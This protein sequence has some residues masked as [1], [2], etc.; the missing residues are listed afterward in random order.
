ME[1]GASVQ[2]PQIE[3]ERGV[4]R[5]FSSQMAFWWKEADDFQH[6][7]S[8]HIELCVDVQQQSTERIAMQIL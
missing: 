7:H 2:R 3:I 1:S 6:A 5:C 4:S 8:R